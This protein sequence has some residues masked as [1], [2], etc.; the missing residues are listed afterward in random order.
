MSCFD[1]I[2]EKVRRLLLEEGEPPCERCIKACYA[3]PGDDGPEEWWCSL[4]VMPGE[5]G[6]IK[7]L[8]IDTAVKMTFLEINIL[9]EDMERYND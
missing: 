2:K 7:K 6:C 8:L 9:D 5:E 3:P 1:S 4:K